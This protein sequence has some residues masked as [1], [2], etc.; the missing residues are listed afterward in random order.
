MHLMVQPI[1]AQEVLGDPLVL[2]QGFMARF[3]I[4]QPPSAIGTRLLRHDVD[5][6]PLDT[7]SSRLSEML[8]KQRPL[9]ENDRQQLRPRVLPLSGSAQELLWGYY[10]ATERAQASGGDLEGC[11]SFASKS[12]EQACRIAAA[13]SLWRDLSTTAVSAQ[14]MADGITLAQ[15]YL[16]EA[17]RLADGAVVSKDIGRAERLRVWLLNSWPHE[18][19]TP[20]EVLRNAPVSSLRESPAARSAL[21]ILERHGWLVPLPSGA[22]V[23]G[24]PRKEAWKIIPGEG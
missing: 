1:A 8:E 10:E 3:L 24:A 20:S 12:P 13:L 4:T 5:R 6:K 22:V 14:D 9:A 11:T 17:R 7:F 23:R 2:G 19:I 18:D 16:S 15:Y 21:A